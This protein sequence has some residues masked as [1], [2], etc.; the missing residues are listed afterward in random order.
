MAGSVHSHID[1]PMTG[2]SLQEGVAKGKN[3]GCAFHLKISKSWE[4]VTMCFE[5]FSLY[6]VFS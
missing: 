2:T 5:Q 3:M 6:N 1:K 4:N